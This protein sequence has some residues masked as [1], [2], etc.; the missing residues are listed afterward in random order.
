MKYRVTSG[1]VIVIGRPACTWAMRPG[2]N[3]PRLPITLPKRTEATSVSV[4]PRSATSSSAIRLVAPRTEVGRAALSVL[5]LTKRST[6][7]STAALI[8]FSVPKMF[9]LTPSAG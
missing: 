9:V 3:D 4:P 5:T 7:A 6:S 1:S 2:R 8:R